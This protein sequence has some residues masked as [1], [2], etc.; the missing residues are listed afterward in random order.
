MAKI[1]SVSKGFHNFADAKLNKVEN[2]I[3][4][5]DNNSIL[6]LE[7]NDGQVKSTIYPPPTPTNIQKTIFCM[8]LKRVFVLLETGT[9]CVYKVY[10]RETATLEKIQF[11]KQ[12]KD[13]EG[14]SLS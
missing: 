7:P 6:L 8:N 3:V 13:Y 5:F 14:K 2:L 4:T 11:P 9:I 1:K 12:L 10:K